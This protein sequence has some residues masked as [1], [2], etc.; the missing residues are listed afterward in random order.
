MPKQE[1]YDNVPLSLPM[2][3]FDSL[4]AD[5]KKMKSISNEK[6]LALES[7]LQATEIEAK[8]PRE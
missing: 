5:M 6:L 8:V 3:S 4:I 2:L 7:R 1:V